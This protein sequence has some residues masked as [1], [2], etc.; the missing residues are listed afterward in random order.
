MAIQKVVHS[1]V[2]QQVFDQLKEQILTGAWKPGEKIPSENDLAVQFGVSRVTIRNALQRLSGLGLLETRFGEGSFVRRMDMDTALQQLVPTVYLGKDSL[3][4]V[5]EFRK[6]V[7]GSVCELACRRATSADIAALRTL[8]EQMVR[9]KDEPAAYARCDYA[10]HEKIAQITHNRM[11]LQ[12]DQI[13]DEMMRAAFKSI[14]HRRSNQAG[15][16]C[17]RQILEA[18]EAHDPAR[19]RALMDRH[20]DEMFTISSVYG[21][22]TNMEAM[23]ADRVA[24]RYF[25]EANQRVRE[26]RY[27]EYAQDIRRFVGWLQ[28]SVPQPKGAH[29]AL[30][31]R[32]SY[33]YAVAL[34]GLLLAGAVAVPLNP[35]KSREELAYELAKADVTSVLC[36]GSAPIDLAAADLPAPFSGEFLPLDGFTA[37]TEPVELS[38]LEKDEAPDAPAL[39]LFTSGTTGRAKG[40]TLSQKNLFA[41]MKL[42]VDPFDEMRRELGLGN[43]QFSSFNVLPMFHIAQISSLFSWAIGGNAVNLCCE[44]KYFYR[45]LAAMDSDVLCVVPVLLKSI[46]HDVMK[47]KRA[48][49]GRLRILTC[50]AATFDPAMLADLIRNGFYV[51]QMYG[52]TETC[53]DGAW[54]SS[55]QPQHLA[56]VGVPDPDCEYKLDPAT[57]ELCIRGGCVMLGYY[58][59]PEATAAVLDADGWLHTGD[60]ARMDEDGY[61]YLIGRRD[62]QITL[63]SGENLSPEELE[64]LLANALGTAEVR[65]YAKANKLCAAVYSAPDAPEKQAALRAQIDALNRTLPL[66]KHITAVEFFPEPLPRT[67][68]GKPMHTGA[69]AQIP[70]FL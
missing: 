49:L 50:A 65:V 57:G 70:S 6:T 31:A 40:V 24:I 9:A 25:D 34:F 11:M 53:G 3:R 41:P 20:M 59:D 5:L 12:I 43:V 18:F 4:E 1:S 44:L 69:P 52:L 7:E 19:A 68:L 46:H 8:Y 66:Y 39:I 22:V 63:A 54:N 32:N 38:D 62:R 61:L 51:I 16:R 17:H 10:F 28:R 29:I 42:Y 37:C 15:L 60:L 35:A 55:Q 48:R 67:A 23:Y 27:R 2:S 21:V 13:T 58:N 64:T 47:G 30:L 56:S 14:A 36:D 26:I 45:D 33:A